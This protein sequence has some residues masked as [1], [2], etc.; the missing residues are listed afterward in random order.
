LVEDETERN[1]I[2]KNGWNFVE[3]KFHYTT[4][5]RNMEEYYQFLLNKKK[6]K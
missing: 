1:R 5:I 3:N 6:G 4:L 2:S